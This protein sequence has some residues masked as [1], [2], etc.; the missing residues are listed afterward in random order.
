MCETRVVIWQVTVQSSYNICSL[1]ENTCVNI[2]DVFTHGALRSSQ[3]FVQK[4]PCIPELNWNLKMLIFLR[5][6]K[7]GVTG[8]NRLSEQSRELTRSLIRR[9]GN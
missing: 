4:C 9:D 2:C 5:E 1:V 6:G 3:K 7:A 8:E